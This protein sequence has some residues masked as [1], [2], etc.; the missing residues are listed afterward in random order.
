MSFDISD[1]INFEEEKP[2]IRFTERMVGDLTFKRDSETKTNAET[3]PCEFTLTIQ[4]DDV[5]EM[6]ENDLK[7]RACIAGTVTCKR[8]SDEPMTVSSG[9]FCILI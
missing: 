5:E 8:L 4:S 7:H 9:N 6:I 3:V 1:K 2:G